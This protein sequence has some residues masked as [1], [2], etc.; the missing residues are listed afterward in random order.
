MKK[1]LLSVIALASFTVATAQDGLKGAWFATAQVGYTQTK[2]GDDKSTNT[3]ILPIVGT[4]I[5]PS[6]AVGAGVGMVGIKS[7]DA[8]TT[9]ADTQLLVVQP[10]VRKYWNAA[11]KLYFFGQLATPIISGTEDKSELDITQFGLA[12]SAGFDFFVTKNLSVEISYNMINFSQ[13]TL[14]PKTGEKTTITDFSVA[15]VATP[16]GTYVDVL[17][18]SLPTLT[19]PFSFG[20]KFVF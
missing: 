3:T 4:F 14:K 10:L 8:T 5:S 1:V 17:G 12:A 7:E 13:T 20:F 6:V 15:H 16:E 2:S 18:G 11:G 9:Y 19:T